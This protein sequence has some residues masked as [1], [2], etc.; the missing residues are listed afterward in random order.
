MFGHALDFIEKKGAE[1]AGHVEGLKNG[2]DFLECLQQ[3]SLF[4]ANDRLRVLARALTTAALMQHKDY[5]TSVVT[6]LDDVIQKR[7]D[8][9]HV[10]LIPEGSSQA[11]QGLKGKVITL[12]ETRRLRAVILRLRGEFRNLR[13]AL[14]A[15]SAPT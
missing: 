3:H 8:Y 7:N 14:L 11:L 6:Y 12:E 4:T 10:V 1:I 13:T 15:G 5:R 2:N 9:A